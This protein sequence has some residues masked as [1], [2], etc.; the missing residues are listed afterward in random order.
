MRNEYWSKVEPGWRWHF[1]RSY[2][3]FYRYA[4]AFAHPMAGGL[5]CFLTKPP[6]GPFVLSDPDTFDGEIAVAG[7]VQAFA[8]ALVVAIHRFGWPTLPDITKALSRGF[9]QERR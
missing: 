6:I 3:S 1:R 9:V 2:G 5:D 8:D 4:S 7:A